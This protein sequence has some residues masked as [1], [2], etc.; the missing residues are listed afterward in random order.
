MTDNPNILELDKINKNIEL[1]K[2]NKNIESNEN[3]YLRKNIDEIKTESLEH[4]L[5]NFNGQDPEYRQTSHNHLNRFYPYP[6]Q[7]NQFCTRCHPNYNKNQVVDTNR[8]RSY[9]QRFDPQY[10]LDKAL[11][12]YYHQNPRVDKSKSYIDKCPNIYYDA[13]YKTR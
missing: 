10:R 9:N 12:Y 8:G 3:V 1:D 7:Y 5:K 6:Y 4:Q 2:I 13:Y 11:Y